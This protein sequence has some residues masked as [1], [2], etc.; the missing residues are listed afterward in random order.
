[1]SQSDPKR[2]EPPD[3]SQLGPGYGYA[4]DPDRKQ[5]TDALD[6]YGSATA[7]EPDH[8]G[9]P[10]WWATGTDPNGWRCRCDRHENGAGWPGTDS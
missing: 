2:L 4:C 5:P 6:P 7:V 9:C 1:M 3:G 10:G 8:D